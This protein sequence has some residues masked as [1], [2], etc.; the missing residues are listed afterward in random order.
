MIGAGAIA[1][2]TAGAQDYG[3]NTCRQGYVWRVAR[4]SDLVCVTPQT[5]ADT[6]T[7]NSL[8]PGRTLPNGYCREGYV[9]RVGWGADDLTCVTVKAR[10]Q[11][12]S[13]NQQ[14]DDRRLAVRV[15]TT[16]GNGTL[17]ISGDH[18]NVNGKVR[19]VV[20]GATQR[21]WTVTATGNSGFAGGSFG[22]VTG[23]P[24]PCAPGRP[25]SQ[26]RAIDLTSGRTTS[27]VPFVYC[28]NL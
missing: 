16:S 6:A 1:P 25:N 4:A 27:S 8:A 23:F 15:W 7:D 13:D 19:I 28:V 18:F 11:A 12:Q 26:V 17:K 2:Q 9:W 21:S 24:G 14:A 3:P 22:L 5:R 10:A 20:T